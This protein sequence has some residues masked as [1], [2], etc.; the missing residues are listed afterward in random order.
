MKNTGNYFLH[1]VLGYLLFMQLNLSAQQFIAL[2]QTRVEL[3]GE[4][5]FLVDGEIVVAEDRLKPLGRKIILP[6]RIYK[7]K[8]AQL[9][10]PIF[11]LSGG[12]GFSN[13]LPPKSFGKSK[14]AVQLLTN[15][16]VV[17]VGYRG[18]DG[19]V[20]LHAKK[21]MKAFRAS[22][23]PLLSDASLD[24]LEQAV[25]D[26]A[27]HLK[28]EGIDINRYSMLDV[29]DDVEEV[30]KS[31]NYP[32]IN[33]LSESYGT[34]LALLYSYR[35]PA[36]LGRTVMIGPNPPGH[37]IWQPLKTEQIL[38]LYDSLYQ[39]TDSVKF[40]GSIRQAMSKAFAHMPK[41]WSWYRLDADRI[42][43]STFGALFSRELA[44]SVFDAYFKAAERGDYT[45]LYFIQLMASRN[46]YEAIGDAFAKAYSADFDPR[47]DY[48]A[49]LRDSTTLLGGNVSLLL[50]GAAKGWRMD[51]LPEEYRR[52]RPSSSET[53]V[54]SGNLDVSTPSDFTTTELMPYLKQG[55]HV[56]LK[57]LSHADIFKKT[58]Q[59]PDVLLN[60]FEQG[61]INAEDFAKT[62]P[63]DFKPKLKYS[64]LKVFLFGLI[65]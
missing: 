2:K 8:A 37:F 18:V 13:L 40:Q 49:S 5:F 34:R 47:V 56:N 16:D 19:S 57:H 4:K 58:F 20:I 43:N 44:T 62:D 63:L 41:R 31:L 38:A 27:Y 24:K 36:S 29:L 60:Y 35:Y 15:H 22:K 32:T 48:R 12:P 26:L 54:I 1:L 14:A 17:C 7:G 59:T 9:K 33:L 30:R 65:L 50:W 52:C 10:E 61:K 39:Q 45:G 3:A 53:L 28:E 55:I 23:E 25:N 42:R 46:T 51:L 11:W 21:T 64:K 6:V